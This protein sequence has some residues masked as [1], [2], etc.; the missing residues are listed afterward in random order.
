MAVRREKVLL[1][2]EDR[3]SNPMLRTAAAT[4]AAQ[5]ALNDL[6]G[7]TVKTDRDM[8]RLGSQSGSLAKTAVQSRN[9]NREIDR[10]S[11]RLRLLVDAAVLL[12]PALVPIGAVAVPAV[13][14]LAT[15][16]GA[17]ALGVGAA[18]VAFQ[19]VGDTLKAVNDAAIEPSAE[20]LDKARMAMAQLS[21]EARDLVRQLQD[22]RPAF[23]GLRNAAA[24]GLFPGLSSALDDLD[25]V[26]P[27]VERILFRIGDAA[28]GLGEDLG[29]ALTSPRGQEFLSFIET[30]MP[31]ALTELGHTVGNFAAGMGELWMA[32]TPLN[33][34]V[35]GWL[36]EASRGFDDW[37]Q[38]LS[39]TEGFQDFVAYIRT[40][41]PRVGEALAGIGNAL[42]QI[43]QAAA[44]LGGPTLIALEAVADLVATIAGSPAGP[45]LIALAT[46]LT[47]VSRAMKTIEAVKAS[48]LFSGLAGSADDASRK[49][50]GMQRAAVGA[51]SALA[52]LAIVDAVQGG[53]KD[54]SIGVESMTSSLLDLDSASAD[55]PTNLD[56]LVNSIDRLANP[57]KA[58]ALQDSISNALGGIGNEEEYDKAV[59]QIESLD[60]ALAGLVSQ[61]RPDLAREALE[62][63]GLTEA[64]MQDLLALLPQYGDA[65]AGVG[66]KAKLAG[67]KAAAGFE[68]ATSAVETFGAAL[69]AANRRLDQRDAVTAYER[70]VDDLN[71]SIRENGKTLDKNTAK[72]QANRDALSAQARAAVQVADGM[73]ESNGVAFLQEARKD[74]VDSLMKLGKNRAEAQALA[75]RLLG[76][77]KINAN[78]SVTLMGVDTLM[79]QIRSIN[80]ELDLAS[81]D[82][83][84]Q[85]TVAYAH[86]GRDTAGGIQSRADGGTILGHRYPYRDKVLAY[87]APGEEVISN[88]YGQADKHRA[89][90]KAINA[91]RMANGGTVPSV[92]VG[93]PNVSVGGPSVAVYLDGQVIDARVETRFSDHNAAQ[94]SRSRTTYKEPN[95]D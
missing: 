41:G 51:A 34:D 27:N 48:S 54:Y 44:P 19:G 91:N 15:Q 80:T 43:V 56:G 89:L 49:L 83:R 67:D 94:A 57:G 22:M 55:L 82:R 6:D 32:F 25:A 21:P 62:G 28:G 81:R 23:E 2:L 74:M 45:P 11:G 86:V 64:Q 31:R 76:L 13:T 10:T 69:S 9:L 52:G 63:L 30:E 88:R 79:S 1:E 5:A 66:N 78:P 35:T 47:L 72:G 93:S 14:A 8:D 87:L 59:A 16:F 26:L 92:S 40:N 95:L 37:A 17:A 3:F 18:V 75:D 20:N 68:R 70:S 58:E 33:R 73:K 24:A 77:D 84:T 60:A 12:G 61:G 53:L 36:L 46:G 42:V 29:E 4:R 90:L 38:G 85:I 7:T 50:T 39:Q 71:K 65:I